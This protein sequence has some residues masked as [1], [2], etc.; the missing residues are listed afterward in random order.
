MLVVLS[1]QGARM[2]LF[3]GGPATVGPG[4]VVGRPKNE[5]MRESPRPQD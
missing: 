1:C 2:M 3:T 5:D 4:M